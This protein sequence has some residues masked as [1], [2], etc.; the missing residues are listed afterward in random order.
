VN[1][2]PVGVVCATGSISAE[3]EFVAPELQRMRIADRGNKQPPE[4]DS[5]LS[6]TIDVFSIGALL[7]RLII[8][9]SAAAETALP[10]WTLENVL[11]ARIVD[12]LETCL[13]KAIAKDPTGRF[14]DA[15]ELGV[16]LKSI[17]DFLK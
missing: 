8:G 11:P 4:S 14:H 17:A 15:S 3:N 2:R 13:R 10:M 1:W 12:R 5:G 9:S 16:E 6:P 7:C